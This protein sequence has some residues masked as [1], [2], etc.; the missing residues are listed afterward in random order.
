MTQY[1]PRLGSFIREKRIQAGLTQAALAEQLG[2][3]SQFVA[4]WER[5]ASAP[6]ANR[7]FELIQI[8]KV[9]EA[10]MVEVLAQD[11]LSFWK[12]A[13]RESAFE[14]RATK[15]RKRS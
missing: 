13:V 10:E 9:D 6:P 5:D 11:S 14:H 15:P 7:L 12:A 4:N 1:R 8:L 3:T 2:Y